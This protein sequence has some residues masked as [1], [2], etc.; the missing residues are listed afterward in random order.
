MFRI[1]RISQSD[2]WTAQ[3]QNMPR[4]TMRQ[5]LHHTVLTNCAFPFKRTWDVFRAS[6]FAPNA[7]QG[8]LAS[9]LPVMLSRKP[10]LW[11]HN[12]KAL[13]NTASAPV[14]GRRYLLMGRY[15]GSSNTVV[16]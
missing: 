1:A 3:Y 2:V 9:I 16:S 15:H 11:Q 8:F 14:C 10:I 6:T 4:V 12:Q 7:V 13:K 5:D